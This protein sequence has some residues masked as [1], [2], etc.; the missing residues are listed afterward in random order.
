MCT[1]Y[2]HSHIIIII[3][4]MYYSTTVVTYKSNE[5]LGHELKLCLPMPYI[6]IHALYY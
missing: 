5:V 2:I 1:K 6:F 3:H 4:S